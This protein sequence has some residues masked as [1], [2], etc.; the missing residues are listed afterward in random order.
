MFKLLFD[1]WKTRRNLSRLID[2]FLEMLEM[3]RQVL[4][5]VM[6]V[7]EG[8]QSPAQIRPEVYRRDIEINRRERAIRKALADHLSAHP[9]GDAPT[10]LVLMSI[11]KDAERIGDHAK[12]LV[13]TAEVMDC[14]IGAMTH[15]EELHS[16]VEHV[17]DV[18]D[19]TIR[20]F[21]ESD[22][23]LA[24]AVV[25]D[26]SSVTQGS[27]RL[28]AQIARSD[29]TARE[30]VCTAMLVRFFKR[31]DALLS[32]IASSVFQPVHRLDG[33]VAY[34]KKKDSEKHL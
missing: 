13:G 32:N 11:V 12:N 4:L 18:F 24:R 30:A 29:L 16:M 7:L 28:I 22:A 15:G 34:T 17:T 33:R 6:D 20:A 5:L 19:Q 31:V 10:C 26:E 27:D 14:T 9:G 3:D 1:L 8:R 23:D 25:E 21:R 2:Q